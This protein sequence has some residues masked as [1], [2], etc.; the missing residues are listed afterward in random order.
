MPAA[1][2]SPARPARPRRLTR[3]ALVGFGVVWLWSTA[4]HARVPHA[5]ALIALGLLVMLEFRARAP[6]LGVRREFVATLVG[7]A[8][9]PDF[10]LPLVLLAAYALPLAY[11]DDRD[12]LLRQLSTGVQLLVV[13]IVFYRF[14]ENL[15]RHGRTWQAALVALAV[16]AA[17]A[18]LPYTLTHAEVLVVAL[19][20]GR[21]VPTPVGHVPFAALLAFAAVTAAHL[22]VMSA[23]RGERLFAGLA[24]VTIAIT[25]HAITVRTGLVLLYVG[26]AAYALRALGRRYGVARAGVAVVLACAVFASVAVQLPSVAKKVEYARYELEGLTT[27]RELSDYSDGG[28]VLSLRA[29]AQLIRERPVL[30]ASREGPEPAMRRAYA[31]QGAPPLHLP[32]T[33][34]VYSYV[35]AGLAGLLGVLAV[36][37]APTFARGWRRQPLLA[38]TMLMLALW[39]LVETPLENDL[40]AGLALGALYLAKT[41]GGRG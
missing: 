16:L 1:D 8:R 11:T 23:S 15:A 22:A 25:L 21:A 24:G 6:W 39:F 5:A 35:R 28:R 26:L 3:A 33:Q 30:G 2:D 29:A 9:R 34:Y 7:F 36:L 37:L 20:Q 19:G 13:P 40:S 32:T 18:V 17:A 10:A 41:A 14:R 38:E 27:G 31:E 12:W 4:F